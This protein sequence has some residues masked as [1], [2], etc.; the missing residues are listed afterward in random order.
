VCLSASYIFQGVRYVRT[1]NSGKLAQ[2]KPPL[3][4]YIVDLVFRV[5]FH[6]QFYAKIL[7][8]EF[9]LNQNCEKGTNTDIK[10]YSYVKIE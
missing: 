8:S 7:P 9:L 4:A 3:H 1:I 6:I 10:L 2:F 5:P